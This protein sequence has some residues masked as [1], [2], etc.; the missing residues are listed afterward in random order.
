MGDAIKSQSGFTIAELLVST[1]LSLMVLAGVYTVFR[2]Q[3]HTVKAQE[4]H[5]EAHEYAL[6]VIDL[7][8]REIRNAGYF[9]TGTACTN[10]AN[11]A[12]VV[13]ASST[14]L[15]FVYDSN[16]D[17][18]CEEDITYSFTGSNITR[19]Y[20]GSTETL[21]DGNVTAFTFTYFPQQTSGTA[22]SALTCST[23]C[24]STELAQIQK[25]RIGI[26][27]QSQN[28]DSE[29]GGGRSVDMSVNADLRNRGLSA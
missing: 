19:T 1:A 3:T 12:G 7:M 10:V 27:V 25:V 20:N 2:S 13:S 15:R 4:E 6:A 29:F 11:T 9:P 18:N 5:M 28:T 17:G 16:G 14:S 24:N 26:T 21:T 8:V 23:T 22:P